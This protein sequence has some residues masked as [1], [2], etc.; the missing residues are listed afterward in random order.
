VDRVLRT[1]AKDAMRTDAF[2]QA[3]PGVYAPAKYPK[4]QAS[5][6]PPGPLLVE[7]LVL[8]VSI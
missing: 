2:V 3:E 6:A 5:G 7:L 8:L 4:K 1:G